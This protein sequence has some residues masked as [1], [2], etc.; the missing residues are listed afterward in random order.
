MGPAR[1]RIAVAALGPLFELRLA[2]TVENYDEALAFYRDALGLPVD[3]AFETPEGKGV[4]LA[5]G[6]ATVE[7]LS[8]G[9]AELVDRTEVGHGVGAPIRL[10]IEVA[11]SAE[12]AT[13]LAAAGAEQL[14]AVVETPW[15]HRNVRLKA[16]GG[17][18]ITLFTVMKG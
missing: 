4:V 2:L 18:Q 3:H 17:M 9:Q 7:L 15:G 6:K 16:P 5:A 10:A 1:R 11:D 12:A 13:R 8:T 14:G